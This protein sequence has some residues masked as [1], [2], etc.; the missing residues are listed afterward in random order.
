M[1]QLTD[2][3]LLVMLAEME[4]AYEQLTKQMAAARAE[5]MKRVN[6]EKI[7]RNEKAD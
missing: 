3:E 7:K 2:R 6:E 4:V 5:W 1:E